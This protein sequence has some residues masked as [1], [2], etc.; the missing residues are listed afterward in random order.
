MKNNV[1][2]EIDH[3]IKDIWMHEIDLSMI[4]TTY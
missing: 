3:A 1:V 4:I 2:K